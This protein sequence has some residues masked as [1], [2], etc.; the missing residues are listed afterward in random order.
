[1]QASTWK[2]GSQG[3]E[4]DDA[5]LLPANRRVDRR[6]ERRRS[7][8]QQPHA[9]GSNNRDDAEPPGDTDIHSLLSRELEDA[10]VHDLVSQCIKELAETQRGG[11][12]ALT[13]ELIK[14]KLKEKGLVDQVMA[15]LGIFSG[16]DGG[17][18]KRDMRHASD[19]PSLSP[20]QHLP[21]GRKYLRLSLLGGAAFLE[22]QDFPEATLRIY[23][24]FRQQRFQSRDYPCACEPAF[25]EEFFLALPSTIQY[26]G[27]SNVADTTFSISD[28]IHII[29]VRQEAPYHP[30]EVI[31]SHFLEWR[32]LVLE[33]LMRERSAIKAIKVNGVGAAAQLPA[34]VLHLQ[35]DL[36]PNFALNLQ[37][38][39]IAQDLAAEAEARL[40]HERQFMLLAQRWWDEY[41]SIRASH[42]RRLV[43]L[44]ASDENAVRRPVCVCLQRVQ[45][46]RSLETPREAARFVSLLPYQRREMSGGIDA[47]TSLRW[48]QWSTLHN[49][50]SSGQGDVED[51]ALLL[52]GLL[53]EF[54]L[55]AY[56]CLGTK[57]N[58]DGAQAELDAG[59][60]IQGPEEVAYAW[61]LVRND[62]GTVTF[63]DPITGKQ[64]QHWHIADERFFGQHTTHPFVTIDCVF[65]EGMY[66]ANTQASNHVEDTQFDFTNET[67]WKTLSADVIK[68]L[69]RYHAVG[70]PITLKPNKLDCFETSIKLETEIRALIKEHRRHLGLTTRFDAGLEQVLSP[71]LVSYEFENAHGV[72]VGNEEFKQAIKHKIPQGH[73]F[74][75][76]PFEVRTLEPNDA[77]RECALSYIG[78]DVLEAHGDQVWHA[79][80]CRVY[81]YPEDVVVVWVMLACRYLTIS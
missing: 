18:Q 16:R 74:K 71:A 56:V 34:G 46:G 35:L 67:E 23:V 60:D 14:L 80:R 39:T 1:M 25:K 21:Q 40:L 44:F 8:D 70:Q 61:A 36:V 59:E 55:D 78:K 38:D 37:P 31:S 9:Q 5:S 50:L 73:S 43:K 13:P 69:R 33:G 24:R 17:S 28:P 32:P 15:K 58:E 68:D 47:P 75:G 27:T 66:A 48:E 45:P 57:R 53:L 42:R 26:T 49:F 41:V 30:R 76:F 20:P 65:N 4:P 7:A 63:W 6:G 81:T 52:V 11:I 10:E 54:G 72:V 19:Q 29:V 64:H 3:G 79:I 51:H 12:D 77:F 62:D 2:A 22:Q